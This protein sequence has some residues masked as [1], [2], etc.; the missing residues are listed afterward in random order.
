MSRAHARTVPVSS[1]MRCTARSRAPR[2]S[3]AAITPTDAQVIEI[4]RLEL[5]RISTLGI[6]GFD[7]P[8]SGEAMRESAEALT[9]VRSL[10][11]AV[12][13]RWPRLHSERA[14]LDS[15]LASAAGYLRAHSDFETSDRLTFIAGYA[16]PPRLALDHLLRRASHTTSVLMPR[17][18]RAD[19]PSVYVANAFDSRAYA[20][21]SAP[22]STDE[23]HRTRRA[24]VSG[25]PSLRD[26]N[27]KLCLVPRSEAR[28]YG[29]IAGR[30]DRR[31][32]WC[33]CQAQHANAA[34][35]RVAAATVCR[36]ARDDTGRSGRRRTAKP[37]GNGRLRLGGR[38][39]DRCGR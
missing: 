21:A 9:G 16:E 14:A 35:R 36:R 2:A 22:K 30:G 11:A 37:G 26:G 32:S 24:T 12:G 27:P 38:R 23:S 1:R 25:S 39:G 31:P 33:D 5:A 4:A 8:Q 13:G 20:P 29:W 3:P 28:V 34:Q 19:V 17:A 10:V 7:A 15:T 18:W 6:S